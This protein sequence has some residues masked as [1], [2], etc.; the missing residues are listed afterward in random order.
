[1]KVNDILKINNNIIT[2]YDLMNNIDAIIEI[3]R[4]DVSKIAKSKQIYFADFDTTYAIATKILKKQLQKNHLKS[5]KKFYAS[6]NLSIA[7]NW[8]V[9]RLLNNMRNITTNP[10]YKLYCAPTFTRFNEDIK[11]NHELESML[12]LMDLEKADKATLIGGLKKVWRDS[13]YDIDFDYQ[14]FVYLCKK[15]NIEVKDVI[16]KSEFEQPKFSVLQVTCG[17]KQLVMCF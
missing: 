2:V 9:S 13:K 4:N 6:K 11:S 1:M 17:N 10:K 14:D 3:S 8:L 16:S 5:I 12:E 15:F 7:C